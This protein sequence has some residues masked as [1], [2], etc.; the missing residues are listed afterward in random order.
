MSTQ[1]GRFEILS[2]IAKSAHGAVYKA[3]D[4]TSNQVV[5]LKT[6]RLDI[7]EDQ[8][9]AFVER[10]L[11]ES[12][13]T[14]EL[15]SQNV[16]LLYGAGQIEDQLCAAMEY[17][18]GNSI[19]TMLAR[20]E[21]FSIWDLL[22]ISRQVCAALDSIAAQG[23]VHH[24]LEPA[25]VMVQ[26][27]GLVKLL[28]YG[29]STMSLLDTDGEGRTSP[30]LHYLS[31]EQVRGEPADVRS[32]LFTWG[33]ILYEMVTDQKAF[34]GETADVICHNILN[35]TPVAPVQVNGKIHPAVSDLIM[36]SLAKAPEERFQTGREMLEELERC[37]EGTGKSAA[38]KAAAPPRAVTVPAANRAAA[39]T[40]FV[41]AP[42]PKA[43]SPKP[44]ASFKVETPAPEA[45]ETDH[46]PAPHAGHEQQAGG[47][48]TFAEQSESNTDETQPAPAA[49]KAAAAAAG[50]SS[51]LTSAVAKA[52]GRTP[53]VA[54]SQQFI[55]SVV[56]ASV[57]AMEREEGVMSAATA[58]EVET[59][60]PK[61]AVDPMMAAM[62]AGSQAATKSFSD[63]DELPPLKEVYVPP[64][65]PPPVD[66]PLEDPAPKVVFNRRQPE[67]PKVQPRE[68]AQKA[69]K[70]IK[71]VPPKLM[72]YSISGAVVL[73]LVIAVGV[74][75]YVHSQN[76]DDDTG[77]VRRPVS[78]QTAAETQASA[79]AQTPQ[80]T[81]P[82]EIAA[83]PEPDVRVIPSPGKRNSKKKAAA[84]PAPV[85]V[86]PGQLAMDSTPQ[87]AQVQVDGRSDAGW[88]TPFTLSGLTPGQ[89]TVSV[90][91][92]GYTS[93]TRSIEVS[94]GSKSFLTVHLN[95]MVATLS[96][97][98]Q[99]AGATIIVDGKDTGH[100]TPAQINVDKGTHSVLVRKQGYLEETVNAEAALGQTV[101]VAPTLRA[102]G[103]VDEIKTVGKF[104]KL[105]GGGEAGAGMGTVS[106]KTQPKSAQ[107]AV[108]RR[109]L[110]KSS[111]VEFMLNPGN[112]II[113]ITLSGF[114]PIHKVIT[115]DKGG[116]VAIDEV[117][118]RE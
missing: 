102:L 65:P 46:Q 29:I 62:E 86:V 31:P 81:E 69:M 63:L 61:I 64:P 33:A 45:T 28:G 108:N 14:R 25:K 96:V 67:K 100:V 9:K 73:I 24:S 43:A 78:Q 19:S 111:P 36:K 20:H 57:Q 88:V 40:K 71:T 70:E 95:A 91:K 103:N 35:E 11:A 6:V 118:E 37:K 30:V 105:F 104:K 93:E 80:Q 56:K 17:V 74:F 66:E 49:P 5:A 27:D 32:N 87:G 58:E 13:S 94:S 89:H 106:I 82:V 21:G 99:P 10:V 113:D 53:D 7:P 76:A 112:Y 79:P 18:Q 42:V 83:D 52:T 92:S 107:V 75:L 26:W 54:A 98:S 115:V 4:P 38:K 44:A 1:I 114:K 60:A 109:M 8:T 59:D 12:E 84:A 97:A 23:A 101:H 47:S 39:A 116:K 90:L 85:A 48:D 41:G 72:M 51:G 15:T 110:D 16:A 34:D 2:E 117:M 77:P 55:S 68:V 3:N 22:D 50:W